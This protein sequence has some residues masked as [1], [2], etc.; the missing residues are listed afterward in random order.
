[1]VPAAVAAF[2]VIQIGPV[3]SGYFLSLPDFAIQAYNS[4]LG[5]FALIAA[6][7][8]TAPRWRFA[9]ALVLAAAALALSVYLVLRAPGLGKWKFAWLVVCVVLGAAS[10]AYACIAIWKHERG[11]DE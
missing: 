3:I 1:M 11:A 8:L 4:A 2:F 5:S 7:A 9:T 6:G 10:S